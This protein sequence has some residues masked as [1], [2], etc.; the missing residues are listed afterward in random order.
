M[1]I[2]DGPEDNGKSFKCSRCPSTFTQRGNLLRHISTIHEGK[3][4]TDVPNSKVEESY[5]IEG[6]NLHQSSLTSLL[7]YNHIYVTLN[8]C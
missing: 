4:R 6:I 1:E 5:D 3:K 8:C 7:F 2:E